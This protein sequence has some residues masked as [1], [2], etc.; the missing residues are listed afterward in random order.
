MQSIKQ[1]VVF[2]DPLY[3]GEIDGLI[4]AQSNA[5]RAVD[6]TLDDK[7]DINHIENDS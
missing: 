3:F 7:D 6:P 1:V 2:S 4:K 5:Y